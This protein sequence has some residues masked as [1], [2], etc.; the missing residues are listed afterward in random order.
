MP[1]ILPSELK[2][3]GSWDGTSAHPVV[4]GRMVPNKETAMTWAEHIRIV[5]EAGKL[6]A[7]EVPEEFADLKHAYHGERSG[8][9][10]GS[11]SSV[12]LYVSKGIHQPETNPHI[13]LETEAQLLTRDNPSDKKSK[14]VPRTDVPP[15]IWKYHLNVSAVDTPQKGDSFQWVGVQFSR[16]V[17]N[18]IHVWPKSATIVMKSPVT[19]IGRRNS[20]SSADLDAHVKAVQLATVIQAFEDMCIAFE[21]QHQIK[22]IDRKL[23]TASPW[24][25]P[26]YTGEPR[27]QTGKGIKY[28]YDKEK[29][30]LVVPG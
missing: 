27:L 19:T 17:G 26:T 5:L 15:R 29:G 23:R 6:L 12:E 22:P 24:S 2:R 20:I 8:S 9:G 4:P 28:Q 7:G 14:L 30:F 13:Q 18:T 11:V 21:N 10:T 16:Q 25:K 3:R 1:L